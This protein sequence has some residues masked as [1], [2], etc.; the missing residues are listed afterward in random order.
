MQNSDQ[1]SGHKNSRNA[2]QQTSNKEVVR[3]VRL[4]CNRLSL[5]FTVFERRQSIKVLH[6]H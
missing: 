3:L 2:E 4:A 6:K 5:D 1:N